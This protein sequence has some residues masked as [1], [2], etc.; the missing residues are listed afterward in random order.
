[1]DYFV[2]LCFWFTFAT[3]IEYA[4]INFLQRYVVASLNLLIKQKKVLQDEDKYLA[5]ISRVGSID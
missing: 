4:A 3:M 5:K 1:M 2:L